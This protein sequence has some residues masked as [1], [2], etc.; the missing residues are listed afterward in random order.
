MLVL[1]QVESGDYAAVV[2]DSV[3]A[4]MADSSWKV[5]FVVAGERLTARQRS[6]GN[7]RW[8]LEAGETVWAELWIENFWCTKCSLRYDNRR[9]RLEGGLWKP[10]WVVR[11][12]DGSVV[13]TVAGTPPAGPVV[14]D[15]PESW[16]MM[17]QIFLAWTS[18]SKL[19][20]RDW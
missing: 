6:W 16:P 18:L 9:C 11:D 12:L 20:G 7:P 17:L 10:G 5:E 4:T 19:V 15:L 3:V 2:D 13:G 14:A 8:K 1:R